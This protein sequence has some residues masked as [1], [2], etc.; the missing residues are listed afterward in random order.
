MPAVSCVGLR[1][2]LLVSS[3]YGPRH[4]GWS[5]GCQGYVPYHVG[6]RV[7]GCR[8][9]AKRVSFSV[10][11]CCG[12]GML[13]VILERKHI[14]LSWLAIVAWGVGCGREGARTAAFAVWASAQLSAARSR[15]D[16]RT[17]GGRG[18]C[19]DGCTPVA[20]RCTWVR[21]VGW[22]GLC[23]SICFVFAPGQA[24]G[25]IGAA[26]GQPRPGWALAWPGMEPAPSK[27]IVALGLGAPKPW[28]GELVSSFGRRCGT[29]VAFW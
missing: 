11:R 8:L 19:V 14:I 13:K 5:K 1:L 26:L 15:G 10:M 22:G 6:F 4:A 24:V 20:L 25:T 27:A 2:C 28:R 7:S 16:G 3:H 29:A 23:L 21:C 18:T 12:G 17:Y 9:G